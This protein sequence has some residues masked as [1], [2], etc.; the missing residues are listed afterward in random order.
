MAVS[1]RTLV[2]RKVVAEL[3]RVRVELA[4]SSMS[5]SVLLRRYGPVDPVPWHI[6]AVSGVGSVRGELLKRLWNA[7]VLPM[8]SNILRW[9]QRRFPKDDGAGGSASSVSSLVSVGPVMPVAPSS[10]SDVSMSALCVVSVGNLTEVLNHL[11]FCAGLSH[12]KEKLL[13]EC[14]AA[15]SAIALPGEEP[16]RNLELISL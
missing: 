6:R 10:A 1:W 16:T 15:L 3:D 5:A 2:R 4:A 8:H 12:L 14:R 7:G 9:A 13:V 11:F